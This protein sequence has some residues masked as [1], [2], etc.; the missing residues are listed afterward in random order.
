MKQFLLF[1]LI[2]ATLSGCAS[3]Q[4]AELKKLRCERI[5]DDLKAVFNL[6]QEADI[7]G[8]SISMKEAG[9]PNDII[10]E[11]IKLGESPLSKKAKEYQYEEHITFLL[12]RIIQNTECAEV[13]Q[14]QSAEK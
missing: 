3:G 1:I 13:F 2:T 11:I 9:I 10:F 7:F 5:V 8:L 12:A 4:L 14:K 6:N